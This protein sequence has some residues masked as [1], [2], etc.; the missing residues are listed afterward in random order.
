MEPTINMRAH[1]IRKGDPACVTNV[2]ASLPMS[3]YSDIKD[4]KEKYKIVQ[5][6]E[7]G[8][9]S[10]EEFE[11]ENK[12]SQNDL[13]NHSV[14]KC[15]YKCKDSY[16]DKFSRVSLDDSIQFD[17]HFE[18]ANLHSAYRVF[19]SIGVSTSVQQMEHAY[20]LYMSFDLNSSGSN[21]QWFY[22]KVSNLKAGQVLKFN[23]KNYR[24]ANSL[25][26]CGMRPLVYSETERK[27]SRDISNVT[28][29]LTSDSNGSE[30][31]NMLDDQY[32]WNG[33][34]LSTT[35]TNSDDSG[36]QKEKPSQTFY[37]LSFTYDVKV[38]DDIVYFAFSYPYSYSLLQRFI[39]N[40]ETDP[41]RTSLMRRRLLCKTIAGNRCDVLTITAPASSSDELC[42][43][44]V[45]IITARVHPGETHSSLIAH[46]LVDFL[47]RSHCDEAKQLR[48]RYIFKIIPMLNPD[49]VINGCYRSS[50][51][52]CDLNRVWRNPDESLHPT[53]FH[54]KAM[55]R[56]LQRNHSIALL[57]DLHGHSA[58]RGIL[59]YG[60]LAGRRIVRT[61]FP[62]ID[63][64]VPASTSQFRELSRLSNTVEL[65]S[66]LSN[67]SI[68]AVHVQHWRA[69]LFPSLLG[70]ISPA[71]TIS[72]CRYRNFTRTYLSYAYYF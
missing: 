19:E 63:P 4:S 69:M 11:D 7:K 45:V 54:T 36:A 53:L 25:F 55:I 46:G 47:T 40:I 72:R 21:L 18:S 33:C 42:R 52:G 71:F 51:A 32:Y 65:A 58:Q 59:T 28:Y 67:R 22:F 17:S 13:N 6:D 48:A 12:L 3:G 29:K 34:E 70:R 56:R 57:V 27:W 37:T 68:T 26:R 20:D 50:L 31:Q 38:D 16:L 14:N 24:K 62:P 43:R 60:C 23:I 61:D 41:L 66:T 44:P 35:R 2:G 5:N 1:L 49:G 8:K 15:V 9:L 10:S 64:I 39:G 30:F